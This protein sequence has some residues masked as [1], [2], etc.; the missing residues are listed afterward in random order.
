MHRYGLPILATTV[1]VLFSWGDVASAQRNREA[2]IKY[3]K[4]AVKHS[5]DSIE[6]LVSPSFKLKYTSECE[7]W[8]WNYGRDEENYNIKLKA[9]EAC[10]PG[11]YSSCDAACMRRELAKKKAQVDQV[12]AASK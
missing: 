6:V 5:A 10:P 8:R 4:D 1:A 9:L 2:C 7:I 12:C 11:V 3:A